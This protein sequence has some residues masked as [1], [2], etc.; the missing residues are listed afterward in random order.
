MDSFNKHLLR[1][2]YQK[3]AAAEQRIDWERF[4]PLLV[5]L[6]TNDTEK[7]ETP[8]PRPRLDGEAAGAPSM[9]W[10]RRRGD[11]APSRGQA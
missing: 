7:E 2:E 11:R 8:Q 4:R 9:V 3:L 5:D 1:Q 10:A 6:Y